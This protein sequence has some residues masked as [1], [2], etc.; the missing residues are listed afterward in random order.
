MDS[1]YADA[2]FVSGDYEK[3]EEYLNKAFGILDNMVKWNAKNYYLPYSTL[4][5]LLE[6]S[7]QYDDAAAIY[8]QLIKVM[9]ANEYNEE[10]DIIEQF[11]ER[12]AE[13]QALV[14]TI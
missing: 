12:A 7:R 4:A 8:L 1:T 2:Y 10:D 14:S 11:K 6:V 5:N 3:T 13:L 9:L